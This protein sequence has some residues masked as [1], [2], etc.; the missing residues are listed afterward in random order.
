M[1]VTWYQN[2][3]PV[4]KLV[5]C[6]SPV[7]VSKASCSP[8]FLPGFRTQ[9]LL[10]AVTSNTS[11]P[12]SAAQMTRESSRNRSD[13]LRRKNRGRVRPQYERSRVKGGV[14]GERRGRESV[15]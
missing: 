7:M 10:V 9:W 6:P 12:S 3:S 11:Q 14:E 8:R 15:E 5:R 2:Q 1:Y 4:C 13:T